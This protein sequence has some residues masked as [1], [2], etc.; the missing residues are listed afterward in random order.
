MN[1]WLGIDLVKIL[2]N[3]GLCLVMLLAIGGTVST[4][5][6]YKQNKDRF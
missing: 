5:R 2:M 1:L 6:E 3:A 4:I